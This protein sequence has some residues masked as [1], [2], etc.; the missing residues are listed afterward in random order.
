MRDACNDTGFIQDKK[1]KVTGINLGFDFCAEHEWGISK[2]RRA[3]GVGVGHEVGIDT[4]LITQA[5]K[6]LR[7]IEKDGAVCLIYSH[8]Y[9]PDRAKEISD[10]IAQEQFDRLSD[11]YRNGNVVAAWDEGSFAVSTNGKGGETDF[12]RL[13]YEEMGKNNVVL[14]LK[15]SAF[16]GNGLMFCLRNS[17]SKKEED[18]ILEAHLSQKRL[19][20]YVES[21][22]ILERLKTA[23]CRYF[24][25]SPKW[26]DEFESDVIFWLNPMEQEINNFGWMTVQDLDDWIA[27]KGKVITKERK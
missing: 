2:L 26:K 5:P 25:C 20:A 12:L 7:L 23:N 22:G 1:G 16:M 21:T 14:G 8:F 27:G 18:D 17:Y 19:S 10:R 4:N 9:D 6:E 11:K 3:F 13:L 15:A 24:A